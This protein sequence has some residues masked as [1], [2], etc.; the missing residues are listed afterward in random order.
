[1]NRIRYCQECDFF[2]G[3]NKQKDGRVYCSIKNVL[4][5]CDSDADQSCFPNATE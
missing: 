5:W 1:M 4:V 3:A 2:Q